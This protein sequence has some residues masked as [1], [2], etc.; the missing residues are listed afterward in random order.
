MISAPIFSSRKGACH[1]PNGKPPEVSSSGPPGACATPSSV[2]K[3]S[4]KIRPRP[5]LS[6]SVLISESF[7][8]LCAELRGNPLPRVDVEGRCEAV[9]QRRIARH[10]GEHLLVDRLTGRQLARD[11]ATDAGARR[12]DELGLARRCTPRQG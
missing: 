8:G 9:Q 3:M 2:V 10:D 5:V 11:E 6:V 4:M 12:E 7:R 1:P